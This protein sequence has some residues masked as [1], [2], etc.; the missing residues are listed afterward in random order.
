MV[1]SEVEREEIESV[2]SQARTMLRNLLGDLPVECYPYFKN[3]ILT[4]G[5]FASLFHAEDPNDWDI[6]LRDVS[7]AS[8]FE[9]FVV[10]VPAAI[11][12][13]KDVNPAY[14][15]D[16]K[17]EGKLVTVNA[18]TFKNGLQVITRTDKKHR[19]TF[20][21]IHCMPYFDMA[22][23]TLHI[24]RAQYDAIKNKHLIQNPKH[25]QSPAM[26]RVEKFLSRGWK[27]KI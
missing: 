26:H 14:M 23:Q 9:T 11:E 12:M 22:T 2:K 3:S 10:N 7:T 17:L 6:Y 8:Q 13:V 24:S 16:V 19:E 5:C 1:F 18:V 21:F 4:G 20:D 25:K 15:V 27:T